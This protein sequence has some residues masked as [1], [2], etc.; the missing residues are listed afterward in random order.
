MTEPGD[1]KSF[2]T[3]ADKQL[4]DALNQ[5]NMAQAIACIG[6]G[7]DVNA[8]GEYGYTPLMTAAESCSDQESA[9]ANAQ[10]HA[11]QQASIRE[12]KAIELM[13]LLLAHGAD[14][15]RRGPD[16]C[17]PLVLCILGRRAQAVEF[18]LENGADSTI[19]CFSD[20]SEEDLPTA[21]RYAMTDWDLAEID[22]KDDEAQTFERI[23]KALYRA[24]PQVGSRFHDISIFLDKLTLPGVIKTRRPTRAEDK[25]IAGVNDKPAARFA[26]H[27]ALAFNTL[28][29]EW[30]A[31]RLTK[32]VRYES[33]SVFD[34]LVG[35]EGVAEYFG[36]KIQT[37]RCNSNQRV[38]MQLGLT[39]DRRKP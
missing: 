32:S 31:G 14:I 17:T 38:A 19:E 25:W 21:W 26:L 18:L 39:P 28:D 24:C 8:I 36:G 2:L 33:Q 35:R 34:E 9:T 22:G 12:L 23:A 5:G 27:Y 30:L 6:S 1:S 10:E 3:P 15:D 4:F 7:A 29:S 11:Q 20:A 13:R 37:L 16:E